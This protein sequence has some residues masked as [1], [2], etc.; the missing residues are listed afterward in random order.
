MADRNDE[1]ILRAILEK[2]SDKAKQQA[3]AAIAQQP[4]TPADP[5]VVKQQK[6]KRKGLSKVAGALGKQKFYYGPGGTI[7]DKEGAPA[8]ETI[9]RMLRSKDEMADRV[10]EAVP[11]A[12][13][14]PARV[15]AVNSELRKIISGT[16]AIARSHDQVLNK[17]PELFGQIDLAMKNLIDKHHLIVEQLVKQNEELQD[18]VIEAL[19]G[20]RAPTRAG[21]A[22]S[23]PKR[24]SAARAVG[25][26]RAAGRGPKLRETKRSAVMERRERILQARE[27]RNRSAVKKMAI[28]G[29]VGGLAAG[30]AYRAI[31]GG[32]AAPSAAPP[33]AP[34]PTGTEPSPG[35]QRSSVPGMVELTTP[36]SKKK[37][38]VAEQY[39][40]NFKGFVDELENSGYT[41]KSI[42]GY[43]NRNIAGTGQKSFHSLGVAIDINPSTNPHVFPPKGLVTDMPSNVAQMAAKYGLG[44]GGNWRSS[45]DA[46]HFSMASAEGGSVGI[47]R[48]GVA[49]LPGAPAAPAPSAGAPAAAPGAMAPAAPAPAPPPGVPARAMAPSPGTP[50]A[51]SPGGNPSVKEV[52]QYIVSK[53]QAM[54][55]NP[56][57][58]LGIA[59]YEGLNPNTIGAATFGNRDAKGYSFGPYQLYSGSPDPTKIAPGGMAAE[60]M[61]RYKQAPSAANWRQQVDFSLELMKR[62]GPAGLERGPW[63]AVR[64]RGGVANIT[65]LGSQYAQQQGIRPG[66]ITAEPTAPA[67]PGAAPAQAGAPAAAGPTPPPDVGAAPPGVAPGAMAPSPGTPNA[68]APPTG[69]R[70]SNLQVGSAADLSKVDPDLL[71]RLYAAVKEY[72]QPVRIN[73][74]YRGDDYQAQLWVRANVYREPGIYSP[75]RPAETVTITYK[76]KQHT[77]QGSGRGST[78]GRGQAIDVSPGP[79]LD[80][81]LRKHGL[82]RPHASFDPPHV[83]KM[84]GSNYQAP[85]SPGA[86]TGAPAAPGAVAQGRTVAEGSARQAMNENMRPQGPQLL[87]MNNTRTMMHTRTVH[88]GGSLQNMQR[89]NAGEFNPFDVAATVATGFALGKAMRLF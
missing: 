29:A 24:G 11:K 32:G 71:K 27:D 57:M 26:S 10:R 40:N 30:A 8:P 31:S 85:S 79:A 65:R 86:P 87:I 52:A 76:G 38:V 84:G 33:A 55:V 36:I 69:E 74:A 44:W 81:F 73:S 56:N 41:I 83:E 64:D 51:P 63:Y 14:S 53:A 15:G 50:G 5:P 77:V 23:K 42:G 21:G 4:P 58:A 67:A 72:G 43:A 22:V 46:M 45:K 88:R 68:P 12:T 47:D 61:Q 66:E 89:P 35:A 78:H 80:P 6:K 34:G 9:A 82:H 1:E 59:A 48:S 3:A 25:A 7:V 49:P 17:M 18:K 16:S 54:G 60:F 28:A 20:A 37:F 19:T 70:P 13:A 2:G 75:A 62:R 39:A